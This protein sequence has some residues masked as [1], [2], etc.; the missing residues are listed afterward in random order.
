METTENKFNY[1]GVYYIAV[2]EKSCRGCAFVRHD[3]RCVIDTDYLDD[4]DCI[5][6]C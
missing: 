6:C 1:N 4:Y 5:P 2:E 3:R